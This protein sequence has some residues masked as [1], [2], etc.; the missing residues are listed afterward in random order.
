MHEFLSYPGTT[1]DS[2]FVFTPKGIIQLTDADP[3]S[4]AR[5]VLRTLGSTPIEQRLPILCA[6]SNANPAQVLEKVR[7]SG[8]DQDVAF[9][10]AE[11]PGIQAVFSAHIGTY[12]V[13]PATLEE[14][15]GVTATFFVGFYTRRQLPSLIAS[16]HGNYL[17]ST[18]SSA[19]MLIRPDTE[20]S[21]CN[22]FL[23]RKGVLVLGGDEPIPL[24]RHSQREILALL[25]EELGPQ[26][27]LPP[28]ADYL[29]SPAQLGPVLAQAIDRAD[30]WRPH[31]LDVDQVEPSELRPM[32]TRPA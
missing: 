30:L 6:G 10:L 18:M 16:E 12:G 14:A 27:S 20:S 19:A 5:S 32:P 23:S 24:D 4:E 2:S 1:P 11:V 17:L 15:T 21:A 26:E 7:N 28:L 25:F 8:N 3:L 31:R 22:F 13:V 29:A 9:L